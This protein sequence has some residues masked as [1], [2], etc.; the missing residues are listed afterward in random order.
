MVSRWRISRARAGDITELDEQIVGHAH[1]IQLDS[2]P[3][4][5]SFGEITIPPDQY[6]VLGDNRNHSEDSRVISFV[7]HA[8][9]VG[10]V[11]RVFYNWQ[12]LNTTLPRISRLF[13]T[14]R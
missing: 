3:A 14:L 13:Q 12:W 4:L 6:F 2:H 1:T 7:P 9:I 10:R 5:T 11:N 8:E